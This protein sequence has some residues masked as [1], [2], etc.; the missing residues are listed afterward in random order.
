MRE[1]VSVSLVLINFQDRCSAPVLREKA[2]KKKKKE[3]S[4]AQGCFLIRGSCALPLLLAQGPGS[5]F[6]KHTSL[7]VIDVVTCQETTNTGLKIDD[8]EHKAINQLRS[9]HQKKI[10]RQVSD[11]QFQSTSEQDKQDT[12]RGGGSLNTQGGGR[13]LETHEGD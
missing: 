5:G 7:V 2:K 8:K 9:G 3:S 4:P 10:G 11:G 13:R 1:T 6:R 12:R